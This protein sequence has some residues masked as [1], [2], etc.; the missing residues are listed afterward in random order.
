VHNTGIAQGTTH[1]AWL[2]LVTRTLPYL[3][4]IASYPGMHVSTYIPAGSL[5][6]SPSKLGAAEDAPA[7]PQS[8]S[9]VIILPGGAR[10]A[11]P[12][13]VPHQKGRYGTSAAQRGMFNAFSRS[14]SASPR[15]ST[16]KVAAGLGGS[17]LPSPASQTRLPSAASSPGLRSSMRSLSGEATAAAAASPPPPAAGHSGWTLHAFAYK[18]LNEGLLLDKETW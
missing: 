8:G 7:G 13:Y 11:R 6:A 12:M 3:T 9:G 17:S 5:A 10:R 15:P 14:L 4:L 1:R 16:A 18:G 2:L